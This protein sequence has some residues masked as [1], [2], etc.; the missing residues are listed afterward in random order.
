MRNFIFRVLAGLLG[1]GFIGVFYISVLNAE[2]VSILLFVSG[3]YSLIFAL[4]G[5]EAIEKT[6]LIVEIFFKKLTSIFK[7][8]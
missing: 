3:I 1:I 6:S 5:Y 4:G 2:L 7:K 8:S